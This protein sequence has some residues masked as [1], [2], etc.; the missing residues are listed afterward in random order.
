[1][2]RQVL[3]VLVFFRYYW[4]CRSKS[5]WWWWGVFGATGMLALVVVVVVAVLEGKWFT[6]GTGGTTYWWRWRRCGW[7]VESTVLMPAEQA[8]QES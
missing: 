6:P 2:V 7:K 1:L 3:V 8:A 4:V 5:W